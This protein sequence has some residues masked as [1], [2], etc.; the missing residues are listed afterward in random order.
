MTRDHMKQL[1]YPNEYASISIIIPTLNSERILTHCLSSIFLQDYPSHLVEIIIADG[2][3]DDATASIVDSFSNSTD[4]RFSIRLCKNELKTG[5]AG[6]AVGAKLATNEILAFIDSDNILPHDQ[7][8][9]Q[10]VAPFMDTEIIA[11]E[12]LTYTYRKADGYI[13]RYCAL[14]GMND[15]TALF[16]GVYDRTCMLT[17][18]W[19]GL[20]VQT[21]EYDD[22]IHVYLKK[23]P[24]SSI[25]SIGQ[26]LTDGPVAI[27]DVSDDPRIQYPEAAQKEGV[28]SILRWPH[29]RP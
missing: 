4:N 16:I 25:R 8:L 9:K 21:T 3:S 19:T 12:P 5:E 22:Y 6:K 20:P 26:S 13:D 24:L 23:G 2:G 15:P 1:E 18:K 27:Y 14:T 11:A 7:W 29:H 28:S 17:G 10:M